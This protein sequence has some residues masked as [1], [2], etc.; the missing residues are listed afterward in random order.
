MLQISES[1][2][3]SNLES[4]IGLWEFAQSFFDDM[5]VYKSEFGTWSYKAVN[6]DLPMNDYDWSNL[7][8]AGV[9]DGTEWEYYEGTDLKSIKGIDVSEYNQIDNWNT[10]KSDGVEF[11]II[12]AGYRGYGTGKFKEDAMFVD[13]VQGAYDAGINVGVYFVTQAVSVAEAIEE[14]DWLI[15]RIREADRPIS[16]PV[17]LDLEDTGSSGARTQDLSSSER[18]DI[19]IAFCDRIKEYGYTPML[20]SNVRWYL[21]EME[22]ERLTEYSKWFAQYF[23]KPFFPYDFQIWQY[24]NTGKVEG[25]RGNVDLNICMYNF[26]NPP[27]EE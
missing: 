17:A 2:I 13:N 18:T 26:A 19:I 6:K 1:E 25:I 5:F 24:T 16:Y 20:Y 23:N 10:V 11:A 14:A 4:S 22:L 15:D 12:R 27:K 21:D 8:H 7:R 9:I 3:I